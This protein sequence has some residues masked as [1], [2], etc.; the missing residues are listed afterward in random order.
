[1][2]DEALPKQADLRKLAKNNA[3]FHIVSDLSPLSRFSD[4]VIDDDGSG[5]VQAEID[6][7]LDEQHRITI[8]GHVH[9]QTKVQCQRCLEPVAIEFGSDVNLLVVRNDEQAKHV[10]RLFDPLIVEDDS[11]FDLNELLVDELLLALPFVSYHD[12]GQCIN[13]HQHSAAEPTAPERD[14]K[15]NPFSVLAQLRADK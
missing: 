6:I 3:Q 11:E 14:K 9:C 5:R 15:E 12:D 7:V 4:A 8:T 13:N 10:N 1:M 2:I